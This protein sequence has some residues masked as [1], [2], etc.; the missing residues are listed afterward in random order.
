MAV[1]CGHGNE[2]Y[3]SSSSSSSSSPPPSSS[4]PPPSPS[5]PPPSVASSSSFLLWRHYIPMQTFPWLIFSQSALFLTSLSNLQFCIYWYLF[6]HN[7]IIL[8]FSRTLSWLP[9]GLLLNTWLTFLLPSIQLTWQIQFN[10]LLLTNESKSKSPNSC[11][12]SLLYRFSFR[13]SQ[14]FSNI[15][16]HMLPLVLLLSC[17]LL[18]LLF[19][20]LI[21][22][23]IEGKVHNMLY[24]HY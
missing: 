13:S 7:S 11:I 5:S 2:T 22:Y 16:I 14:P 4:S 19:W 21:E 12:N 6:V 23:V 17:R 15:S 3:S 10:R 18:F 1:S 8:F 20:V 24:I 9:W